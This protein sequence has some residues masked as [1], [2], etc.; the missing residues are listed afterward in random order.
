MKKHGLTLSKSIVDDHIKNDDTWNEVKSGVKKSLK[1]KVSEKWKGHIEPLVK[2]GNLLKLASEEGSDI[3]WLSVKYNLLRGLLSFG[4]RAALDV[5][6]TWDNLKQ[7]GK[8]TDDKC[9]RCGNKGTLHHVLNFCPVALE[10]GRYTYRHNSII[11]HLIKTLQSHVESRNLNV[12]IYADI[13]DHGINGGTVPS[14][15]IATQQKPDI[16]IIENDPKIVT[17]LELIVPFEPN[18]DKAHETKLNR[19]ASLV[20]DIDN[21]TP[22]KCQVI[23]LEIGSRGLITK[24]NKSRLKELFKIVGEKRMKSIYTDTSVLA[25]TSSYAIFNARFSASWTDS[26]IFM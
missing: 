3:D 11:H 15:V 2:Q 10:Q 7:W 24:D 5:L 13:K 6:P 20:A 23:C 22:W 18:I 17:L 25:N 21:M 8:K 12:K 19:Y 14:Y 1:E 9:C 4:V 26:D 16:C